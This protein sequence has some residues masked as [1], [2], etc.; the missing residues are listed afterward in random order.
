VSRFSV[1]LDRKIPEYKIMI[2]KKLLIPKPVI[3]S[4]SYTRK[5]SNPILDGDKNSYGMHVE[6]T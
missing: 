2:A 3:D 6:P 4:A 1:Y 5:T